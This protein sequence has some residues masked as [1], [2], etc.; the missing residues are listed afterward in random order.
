[1]ARRGAAV[2]SPGGDRTIADTGVDPVDRALRSSGGLLA[3]AMAAGMVSAFLIATERL[4]CAESRATCYQVTMSA[5]PVLYLLLVLVVVV[6]IRVAR[7]GALDRVTRVLDGA[8]F[9]VLGIGLVAIVVAHIWL[10]LVDL[11][12]VADGRA[13][14]VSPFPIAILDLE[15][16]PAG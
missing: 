6:A 3:T 16:S 13:V 5:S 7:R 15:I 12:A 14:L 2:E 1:M 10:A 11:P 9:V 8:R 4:Y